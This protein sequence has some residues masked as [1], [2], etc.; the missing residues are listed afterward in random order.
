MDKIKA[1]RKDSRVSKPYQH[2]GL[3]IADILGDRK[4]RALYIKLA[5]E[6]NPIELLRLAKEI[7]ETKGVKNR[8]AYFMRM[9]TGEQQNK[10]KK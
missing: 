6:K 5:K 4:H 10:D 9:L 8:G 3:A 2:I 7:E 1:R